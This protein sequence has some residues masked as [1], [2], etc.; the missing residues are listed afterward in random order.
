MR[1]PKQRSKMMNSINRRQFLRGA[2]KN[3]SLRPPWALAEADFIQACNRCDACILACES[4]ILLRGDGGFPQTDFRRGECTFCAACVHS[5]AQN[6]FGDCTT[7]SNAWPYRVIISAT[8]LAHKGVE[9]RICGE[10]CETAAIRFQLTA[11]TVAQ[12]V[13]NPDDCTLCGAC[14]HACPVNAVSPVKRA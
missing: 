12:P 9:C 13:L 8:C 11:K 1:E 14:I 10:V 5:C 6:A 3:L 4:Q 7:A 2:T